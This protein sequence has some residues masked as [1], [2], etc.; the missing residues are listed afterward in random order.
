MLQRMSFNSS[1]STPKLRFFKFF[2]SQIEL[3]ISFLI[4]KS[5]K[6]CFLL[7]LC[8]NIV[9]CKI[10][11]SNRINQ[12]VKVELVDA[13]NLISE[14]VLL[15]KFM[16]LNMISAFD[17]QKDNFLQDFKSSL[18][19]KYNGCCI[20]RLDNHTV[21][22]R[23]RRRLRNVNLILLDGLNSFKVL[24]ETIT[25]NK[26]SFRGFYLFALIKEKFDAYD[27]IFQWMWTKGIINVNV[28][29]ETDG[30][31][32]VM[33]F[34]PFNDVAECGEASIAIVDR[35]VNGTFRNGVEN[36]F[37]KKLKNLHKCPIN[38]TTFERCPAVCRGE[39]FQRLPGFDIELIRGN[40]EALNFTINLNFLN[41]SAQWGT[42]LSN[43][44]TTGAIAEVM[45]K[46]AQIII[47]N[48]NLRSS[49]VRIMDHS[50]TYFSNPVIFMVPPG[51][52]LTN[53]EKLARPFD[54]TVWILLLTTFAAAFLVIFILNFKIGILKVFLF[55]TRSGNPMINI[56]IAVFGGSQPKLP[57]QTL[58]RFLL[59]KFLIFCLVFRS[60]YQGSLFRFL[61]SEGRK[62]E[63][64]SIDEMVEKNFDIFMQESHVDLIQNSSRIYDR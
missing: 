10:L 39:R 15:K 64:Q 33:T 54:Q 4:M 7:V 40:S 34:M 20:Y 43:G 26:F 53:F 59:M 37:P 41:G 22:Q 60:A 52:K 27:E 36:I 31:V 5:F 62:K 19:E 47:G 55:G 11:R 21:I 42:I 45:N 9:L 63:V 38:V 49:R 18:M 46:R 30:V 24:F 44:T 3:D 48:Y 8:M 1:P 32:E 12:N 57:Q 13:I 6:F 25:P 51:R 23:N 16:T 29:F 56:L 61:Q 2:T 28:I 58:P 35:F 17:N 14:K 50:V